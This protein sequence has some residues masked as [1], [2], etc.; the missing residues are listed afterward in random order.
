MQERDAVPFKDVLHVEL[1]QIA[2]LRSARGRTGALPGKGEAP[3][4]AH[5]AAL[6][7]LAF[8]GGGIRSATFNLGVLQGLAKLRLLPVF[9]YLSTVSG[10]G[11]IGGWLCSWI[12]RMNLQREGIE[13]VQRQL[14][15]GPGTQAGRHESDE[16]RFLRSYSNY[17]TPR[18]GFIS[19]DTWTIATTYARNLVLNLSILVLALAA[20][21]LL[22]RIGVTLHLYLTATAQ[23]LGGEEWLLRAAFLMLLTAIAVV[24]LNLAG[25]PT[26]SS[27][28]LAQQRFSMP[29]IVICFFVIV[30]VLLAAWLC[31]AGLWLWLQ[32]Q[33]QVELEF[34]DWALATGVLYALLWLIGWVVTFMSTKI[35]S[36][37]PDRTTAPGLRRRASGPLEKLHQ[38][39]RA[40]SAIPGAFFA[41]MVCGVLLLALALGLAQWK[42][43]PGAELFVA[44]FGMAL[45]VLIFALTAVVHIG[46]VGRGFSEEAR[47]WWSR[48]G[49]LL[50]LWTTLIAALF[51]I[52]IYGPT[53]M[54]WVGRELPGWFSAALAS[55]W[56]AS[57]VSGA[58]I[59]QRAAIDPRRT[60]RGQRL[61]A[62][63]APYIF[64]LGLLLLL[65][66]LV[67][68]ALPFTIE[69]LNNWFGDWSWWKWM[70]HVLGHGLWP[71]LGVL[72]VFAM[73]SL[74]ISWRLGI[75]E[76]SLHA[77]YRNRLVRCYLGAS[78]R[79]RRP[80]L[81]TG[82]D[83]EDDAVALSEFAAESGYDGPYPIVNAALNLVRGDKLAWQS[84]KA[85]SFVFTPRYCGYDFSVRERTDNRFLLADFAYRPAAEY[86]DAVTLG[87]AMAISGA[88][89]SPNMGYHTSPALAFLMTVFNVRLGWWLGNPRH[90]WTW[91]SDGPRL[92][93]YYLLRELLGVTNNRSSY[94]YLSDGGHFE[95]LGL[96]ELV[97][98]RCRFILACDAA[99]DRE[100]KFGDLGSAIEK[101]RADFGIDVVIDV[102]PI[103][104]RSEDNLS[105]WHCAVGHIRYGQVDKGAPD[106]LLV[107]VKASLTGNEPTDVAAY[108]AR[109]PEFPHQTTADQW[110]DESQFESYRELGEHI[111]QTVL[112][113]A[114]GMRRPT[115]ERVFSKAV[116]RWHIGPTPQARDRKR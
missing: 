10:G 109:Y 25:A 50:L 61:L 87:T 62:A 17:L 85:A 76:F 37:P 78:N 104:Q 58:L 21:L 44:S 105:R 42:Q 13:E 48:L 19:A 4:R 53:L 35:L 59:G 15:H 96:Y 40:L 97:R 31:G 100:M 93:V 32:R 116:K 98:R 107:Y 14:L 43:F 115:A 103:R 72:T 23:R 1:E 113:D 86:G 34:V 80:N 66:W 3:Q 74:L 65:A 75:N 18:R 33:D 39:L 69:A 68:Q 84:R 108:R 81:F 73:L 20:L 102:G 11:Y 6:V 79:Q 101:I 89:A 9:D 29:P 55:G 52:A 22:P 46:F 56:L 67:R 24:S 111:V 91:R 27:R 54:D 51:A 7:G 99:E 95:N 57:S 106:G 47:E 70:N 26:D 28:R 71:L 88:A 94:V 36:R 90:R 60:P 5:D 112:R 110:F 63:A 16:I 92:G 82:F 64:V 114:Q 49:A 38:M 83:P 2:R 8:S 12:K 41:G 45:V 77:G 30:P